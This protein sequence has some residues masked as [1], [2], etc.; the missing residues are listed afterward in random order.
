LS[1]NGPVKLNHINNYYSRG[2]QGTNVF[3][4]IVVNRINYDSSFVPS[5]YTAG[6]LIMPGVVTNMNDSNLIQWQWWTAPSGFSVG[7]TIPAS[8]LRSF[9]YP[10]LG[11]PLPIKSTNQTLVSVTSDVGANKR[12]NEN[13]VVIA[14]IDSLDQMYTYNTANNICSPYL[15]YGS[16]YGTAPN[17]YTMPHYISFQ[18]SVS[19][20]SKGVAYVDS[21]GDGMPNAWEIANGFNPNVAD[22]NGDADSDGYT[23]LEEFLNLVDN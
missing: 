11:A 15:Y 19:G 1:P 3:N 7:D 5:I 12:L 22:G 17:Y 2:C 20:T 16:G 4:D 14:E 13:G 8:Y 10:L 6:N 23:N 18:S 9:A 21:D